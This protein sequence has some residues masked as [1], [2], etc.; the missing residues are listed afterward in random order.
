MTLLRVE[1]FDDGLV[2]LRQDTYTPVTHTDYGK[3]DKGARV[4]DSTADVYV[5]PNLLNISSDDTF[6]MGGW[7]R[8]TGGGLASPSGIN[9]AMGFTNGTPA[10][11]LGDNLCV[12]ARVQSDGSWAVQDR[13]GITTWGAPGSFAINTWYYIELQFT[14]H[15][16]TGSWEVQVDGVSVQSATS[17]N[18]L[19][20]SVINAQ[21]GGT[22]SYDLDDCNIVL[23]CVGGRLSFR[24]GTETR[25]I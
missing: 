6:T 4:G 18:T 23:A 13:T 14:H 3:N 20:G 11:D 16:T 5:L 12:V 22:G 17:R 24:P 9:K 10:T 19:Y 2:S 15:G 21:W 7:M 1:G 8:T 25:Q